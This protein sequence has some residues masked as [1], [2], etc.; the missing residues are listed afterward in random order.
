MKYTLDTNIISCI[1]DP[2][3]SQYTLFDNIFSDVTKKYLKN[4]DQ[5]YVNPIIQGERIWWLHT[6]IS[7]GENENEEWKER[8]SQIMT[9]T[10]EFFKRL[11]NMGNILP[12]N[13]DVYKIYGELNAFAKKNFKN[14]SWELTK[15]YYEMHNDIWIASICIAHNSILVTQK[16]KRL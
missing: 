6:W 14:R 10:I 15:R 11:E 9:N 8:R 13:D 7:Y 4:E 2:I 3:S 16:H 12:Y 1:F 5:I